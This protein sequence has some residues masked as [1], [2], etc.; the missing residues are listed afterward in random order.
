[1]KRGA[2]A[3]ASAISSCRCWPWLS[4]ATSVS[5]MPSRCTALMIDLRLHPVDVGGARTQQ[6][7]A[8]PRDAAAGEEDA[9]ADA[10]AAEQLRDLVGAPHAAADALMRRQVGDVLAEEA[11]AAGGRHEVAGDGVEQRRLAGAV[12]AEH[13]APFAGRD[14]HVD[15]GERHQRAEMPGHAFELE[16]MRARALETCRGK[17]FDKHWSRRDSLPV[18]QA[19]KG[20][21][22]TGSSDC[23]G[24]PRRA[25]G[26][27]LRQCPA[28]G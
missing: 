19:Q 14:P 24:R 16:R 27:R 5:A 11:D 8:P 17:A 28:S 12:G 25:S 18:R 3:S 10:Q 6:R 9:V 15:A 23:R 26:T 22:I 1:M 2:P 20:S 4:V 21:A 13:R 7:K